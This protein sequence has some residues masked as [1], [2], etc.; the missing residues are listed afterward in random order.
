VLALLT[1]ILASDPSWIKY[2]IAIFNGFLIF[3]SAIGINEIAARVSLFRDF[4]ISPKTH[5]PFFHS[6][7]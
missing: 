1:A 2:I 4:A 6:W 5:E 7:L 3:A